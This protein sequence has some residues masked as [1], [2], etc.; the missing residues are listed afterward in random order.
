[1][2]PRDHGRH[3]APEAV[4]GR[5]TV[6]SYTVNHQQWMP[7]LEVPYVIAVV[8]IAEQADLRLTTNVVGCAPDE[9][10]IGMDVQV[11]FE[12]H[13]VEGDS[14]DDVWLPLFRPA[15]TAP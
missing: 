9:V 5:A 3:V 6:A 13:P 2:C 4:S 14:D 11:C 7:G 8:E 12:H 15:G 10:R 1:M